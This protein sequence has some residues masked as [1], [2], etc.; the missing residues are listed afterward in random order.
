M[1]EQYGTGTTFRR[2]RFNRNRTLE[3]MRID[4]FV[5]ESGI[6]FQPYSGSRSR[7]YSS[8]FSAPFSIC[9]KSHFVVPKKFTVMASY[10]SAFHANRNNK[11]E[12][13]MTRT[14]SILPKL[15]TKGRPISKF[16]VLPPLPSAAEMPWFK[17]AC[18]AGLRMSNR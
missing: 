16:A 15:P 3:T 13:S 9:P 14:F 4:L 11:N 18:S 2:V 8:S 10:L 6:T 7:T 12:N 1:A 17:N 5:G